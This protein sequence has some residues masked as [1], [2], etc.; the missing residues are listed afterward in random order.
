MDDYVKGYSGKM[1][2]GF[3]KKKI[4]LGNYGNIF[5]KGLYVVFSNLYVF[6]NLIYS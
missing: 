3:L 2:K 5:R 1:E 4:L 6:K